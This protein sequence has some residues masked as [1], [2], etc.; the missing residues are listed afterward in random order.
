MSFSKRLPCVYDGFQLAHQDARIPKASLR[1]FLICASEGTLFRTIGE[2]LK[3]LFLFTKSDFKTI[4]AP[5]TV[6]ILS[7]NSPSLPLFMQT[8]FWT[9]LHVLQCALANQTLSPEEDALNKPDRPIPAGRISQESARLLRWFCIIPC[10]ALSSLYSATVFRASACLTIFLIIYNELTFNSHWLS[11]NLLNGAGLACFEVGATLISAD[12]H[13]H[14]T[15]V[16]IKAV[17]ISA[18]VFLTTIHTQ[19]FKD[20][21][22]DKEIG[23]LTLPMIFPKASRISIPI[24]LSLWS[25]LLQWLWNTNQFVSNILVALS[26]FIGARFVFKTSIVAD[27][28]SFYPV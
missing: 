18:S 22:G 28:R 6:I 10:L 27:Q 15:P 11:R 20:V 3:T 26:I 2:F 17:I 19:D 12:D 5:V 24:L 21:V 1:W 14:L 13:T 9:W 8:V 16:A 25:L 23:R 4:I 7:L